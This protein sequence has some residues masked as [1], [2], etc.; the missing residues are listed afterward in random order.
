MMAGDGPAATSA[1]LSVSPHRRGLGSG[2]GN[3]GRPAE[4]RGQQ[5]EVGVS[6]VKRVKGMMVVYGIVQ[7][8]RSCVCV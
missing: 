2:V 1:L 4:G 3:L 7:G 8:G 6:A 5:R